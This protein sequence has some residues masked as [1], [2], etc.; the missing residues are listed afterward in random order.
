MNKFKKV[1]RKVVTRVQVT[2]AFASV[3]R[4]AALAPRWPA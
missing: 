2:N 3:R 1:G 4:Q